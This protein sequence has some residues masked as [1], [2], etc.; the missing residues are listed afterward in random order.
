MKEGILAT[1]HGTRGND[2]LMGTKRKETIDG[3][4]GNDTITGGKDPDVLTGGKGNDVFVYNSIDDSPVKKFDTITDFTQGADKIDLRPLLGA[5]DLIFGGTTPTINGVW[6]QQSGGKTFVFADVTGNNTPDLKI[7]LNGTF[8]LTSAD[9]LGVSGGDTVAPTVSS[10]T[11]NDLVITDADVGTGTFKLAV[12]FSEAMKTSAT[13]ILTFGTSVASTL[14]LTGGVW[15]AGNTVYTATYKVADGNEN[16]TNVTVDVTGAQDASGNAQLNYTELPEFSIDTVNPTVTVNIVDASLNDG[17]NSSLVTFEF[18][19]NVRGFNA[20]DLTPVGVALSGFTA[21][22]GDSYTAIFTATDGIA[23]TGSVTVGTGYTDVAGNTGT[24]GADTV[25]IDTVN[26]TVTVNIVDASLNDGDN[27]SLVTFEFSENVTGF[28]AGDLTPVGGALSGFTVIDSDSYT[29]IFTATDGIAT[30]GSVTVGT[31]YTDVAGN[32]VT[33][34]ADMVAIDTENPGFTS[35]TTATAIDENSG[36][37]QVVYTATAT[38]SSTP[39][40]YSFGGGTDDGAFTI[41]SGTGAVTLTSDPNY[42]GQSSYSFAVTATDAAGNATTQTVTLAINN[43]D[44]VA[45]GFTSGATAT[46][47]DENS[48]ASQV[49]YTATATDPASDTGPS[50]PVTYS[51]GG[52]TDDGAFT[53]DSGTGAVTLTVDPDFETKASY[54]F[55]V[56]ATDAAGNATTQTVTLAINNLDEIAP[57]FTSGATAT[58]IDENSGASQVVYT[59]AATDPASDTGP[60]TPVTYSFGGGTDDG[61][62]TIDS[63]TGAVTLT[64]DPDFE[65]KAS[66]SFAVTATDAA[67][68]ATTQTVTLAI[69]NLDEVAPTITSG[70]T[71]TAINENSGASQVVYTATATDSADISAGVTFSLKVGGDFAAF[72][73][74]G[75]TGAVT[76]TADPDFETQSSYSFTV[77]ASDG[78]NLATEQAV[79][80]A[81]TNL[82][83]VAPSFTSD[84]TANPIDEETGAGQLIYDAA[85]TDPATDGGP[86][87]PVTYSFGGGT[88]DGAFTIDSGTGAVT[89]TAD[90]DF[91]TKPSYSFDVTATDAAGND[92]TQTVTLVINDVMGFSPII[93]GATINPLDLVISRQAN[94]LRL[95]IHG[96]TDQ[97]TIQNWYGGTDNQVETIQAGNG[98]TLLSTQVDQMIQAMAQF[99]ANNN[100]LTWDQGIAQK[101]QEVQEVLAANWQ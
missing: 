28:N 50:T 52:G 53:I 10:V 56:T 39:V 98:Q 95:A 96:G 42:E 21:I 71:A 46:A 61:A 37:G 15:S 76:L 57:G 90:P 74:D 87:N 86:S 18:S 84:V 64:V 13:P 35:V 54:S 68:N 41:D 89:L 2:T 9:F 34:G 92:T 32:T 25:A 24:A 3:R 30:T 59:A 81:I 51:F 45:P 44:E 11:A 29:A 93:D 17:D 83:E 43:L 66:Y 16:L 27:S 26:P 73:I 67:G 36:A 101:P 12:T 23:T 7:Q 85:A 60:S 6:Y 65:T 91:E 38:D 47:I 58:A 33:A 19:E 40:T 62:F 20:G 8:T 70:A 77:L 31:G 99:S 82:D 80:L 69:N 55:A 1:I 63:G 4:D 75:G 97:V 79:S 48:G 72:S 88:D 94:D 14:T 78:V 5:T 49:V 100:G 22:D